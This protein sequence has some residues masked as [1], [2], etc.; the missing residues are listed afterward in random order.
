MFHHTSDFL[1]LKRFSPFPSSV[2]RVKDWAVCNRADDH[3]WCC[4]WS[5]RHNNYAI[6][7]TPSQ[8]LRALTVHRPTQ[9]HLKFQPGM[10]LQ[11][12]AVRYPELTAMDMFFQWRLGRIISH[13]HHPPS[14]HT[15]T[16][17]ATGYAASVLSCPVSRN[18]CRL[19]R[20]FH[21][22]THNPPGPLKST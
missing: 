17:P 9:K 11:F 18:D 19:N 14:T 2:W 21:W 22:S 12:W 16:N 8:H 10:Y 7:T 13:Y 4:Q 6:Y 20:L 1:K 3:V 15:H 5:G